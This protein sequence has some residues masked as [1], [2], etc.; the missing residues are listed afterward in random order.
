CAPD[1]LGPEANEAL[2]GRATGLWTIRVKAPVGRRAMPMKHGDVA[3]RTSARAGLGYPENFAD[4]SGSPHGQSC[5]THPVRTKTTIC[6]HQP[7]GTTGEK[8]MNKRS[9]ALCRK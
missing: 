6:Q 3:L 1:P 7:L 5:C 8:S 9:R 2:K 4:T